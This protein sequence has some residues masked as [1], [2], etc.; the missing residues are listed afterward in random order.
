MLF[1]DCSIEQARFLAKRVINAVARH[2]FQHK[3]KPYHLKLTG[4]LAE[5]SR[6]AD[7]FYAVPSVA[8]EACLRAKRN[9]GSLWVAGPAEF[10]EDLY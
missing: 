3:D 9:P 1:T 8:S 10:G 6:R 4:G 2:P 5:V 7:S